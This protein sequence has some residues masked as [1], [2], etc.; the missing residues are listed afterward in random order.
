MHLEADL[1]EPGTYSSL[2]CPDRIRLAI[3][4]RQHWLALRFL[5]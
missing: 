2:L 1:L 4:W 3:T 5:P